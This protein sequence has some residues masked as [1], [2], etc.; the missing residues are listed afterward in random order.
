[1]QTALAGFTRFKTDVSAE[2]SA[3]PYWSSNSNSQGRGGV[4]KDNQALLAD[5]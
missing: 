5:G 2:P 1:M 3:A 4:G